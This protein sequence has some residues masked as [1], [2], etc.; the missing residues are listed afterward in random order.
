[1]GSLILGVLAGIY[2][3]NPSARATVDMQIKR[4][5]GAG[6]DSL[7]GKGAVIAAPQEADE[8]K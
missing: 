7:N 3:G 4:A 2:I 5:V 6:I 8:E 1:M